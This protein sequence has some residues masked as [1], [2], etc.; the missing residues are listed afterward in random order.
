MDFVDSAVD[1][2]TGTFFSFIASMVVETIVVTLF[3]T[4]SS[5]LAV[6]LTLSFS[7]A[8]ILDLVKSVRTMNASRTLK[9]F[10]LALSQIILTLYLI[11]TF[12][13]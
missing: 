5:V 6:L 9:T 3:A 12:G 11:Q 4:L 7:I 13:F 8:T 10:I 1:T 2:I